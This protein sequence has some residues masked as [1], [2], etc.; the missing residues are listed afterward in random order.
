MYKLLIYVK[1]N[2]FVFKKK[3]VIEIFFDVIFWR[4]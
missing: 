2:K 4:V 3:F 1:V